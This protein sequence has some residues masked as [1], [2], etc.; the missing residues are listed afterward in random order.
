MFF[1]GLL[2]VSLQILHFCLSK[3][4]FCPAVLMPNVFLPSSFVKEKKKGGT[5][6]LC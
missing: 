4:F 5:F 2:F 3:S 1:K 6:P